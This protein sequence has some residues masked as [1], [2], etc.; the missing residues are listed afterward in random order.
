MNARLARLS[1]LLLIAGAAS[2]ARADDPRVPP[3]TA[4]GPKTPVKTADDLPRH[5]YTIAGKASEFLVSDK[6]FADFVAKVK[7]NTEADLA[8]YDIQDKTTLQSYYQ[9]LQQI[10]LFQGDNAKVLK[11]VEQVRELEGKESKKLMTGQIIRAYLAGKEAKDFNATFKSTLKDSVSKL[12]WDKVAEE[13]KTARGRAQMITRDLILGQVGGMLDPVVEQQKGEVSGDLVNSLVAM[14]VT[15]DHLLPVQPMVAEVYG[16]IIDSNATERKDL[17]T[18]TLVQFDAAE[19][20]QP[21]VIGIWD[22]GVDTA[23]FEKTGQL[24]TNTKE[25]ANGKD[26]D[27]NGFVDDIHGIAYNLAGDPT[28]ELLHPLTEL[29]HDKALMQAHMKGVGDV[30]SGVDSPEAS[31]F[32]KYITSLKKDEVTPFLEDLGLFGNYSHG[33]HVAGIASEGNPFA[34]I[35]AARITFDYKEIPQF[36]PSV[37]LSKKTAK[38]AADTINY[39]KAANVRVVNMSWGGSRKDIENSLEKKGVGKTSEERAE[40]SRSLFKIERDALESAMKSAPDILFVCAAGN[41]DNDNEFSELIPSGLKLPNMITIGAVDSAGK[42][43]SFTTFGKSVKLY[44]NG[45]EVNSYVPGGQKMKFNGTSM[46]SPNA[47]NLAAKL[48]TVNPKLTV[49]QAVALIEKGATPMAGYDGRFIINPKAS[50]DLAR[51]PH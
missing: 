32:R 16:T 3:Q 44:A 38:A 29:K 26:D 13:V 37:E 21:V 9:L 50:I 28:P 17:W 7:A 27:N 31:A 49:A 4:S 30:Q 15:L 19:K 12:P 11:L 23:I 33:T 10:A 6:P 39:F 51:K 2:L 18:P 25:T 45:F 1:C 43:T 41:S 20:F 40:I 46:A 35:L 34:R 14:R 24:W 42:P 5:T 8:K 47:A 48:F 22:S 36:A